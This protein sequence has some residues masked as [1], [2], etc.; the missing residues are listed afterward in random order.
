MAI[1]L[2]QMQLLLSTVLLHQLHQQDLQ[3]WRS[4]MAACG[5]SGAT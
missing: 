3:R 4:K 1:G 5:S 2:Q